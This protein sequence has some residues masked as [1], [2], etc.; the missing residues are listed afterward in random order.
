M[1][2]WFDRSTGKLVIGEAAYQER[3]E[4][5]FPSDMV[6]LA[7]ML[8]GTHSGA[9]DDNNYVGRGER[10]PPQT[11]EELVMYG[12][13][14]LRAMQRADPRAGLE[15]KTFDR[16][17]ALGLGPSKSTILRRFGSIY[18]LR[19]RIDAPHFLPDGSFDDWT[20][21]R[22]VENAARL[23]ASL[24]GRRPTEAQYRDWARR[25]E[26]PG[27]FV[28]KQ[29][30]PGGGL[31]ALNERIG[32][33]YVK[34]FEVEDFYQWGVR[35]MR[36]NDGRLIGVPEL[37]VLS[38][39]GCAPSETAVYNNVGPIGAFRQE[40]LRRYENEEADRGYHAEVLM[41][42][43]DALDTSDVA[44]IAKWSDDKKQQYAAKYLLAEA[45]LPRADATWLK[46]VAAQSTNMF[47]RSLRIANPELTPGY[48]EMMAVTLDIFD[49]I[50]DMYPYDRQRLRVKDDEVDAARRTRNSRRKKQRD[51]QRARQ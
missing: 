39:K 31:S 1:S 30:F 42:V 10:F 17:H 51:V 44:G 20:T 7:D 9:D 43:F 14:L 2:E 40:V 49:D 50:W 3:L 25:G 26:G 41:K 24:G 22:F 13:W 16:A 37:D 36:A 38:A 28:I 45:C 15:L 46:T 6:P 8:D 48:V 33:P 29:A 12:E 47:V 32:F 35:F 27:V 18:A 11:D 23:S 5:A 4:Q 34:A 21:D 19:D